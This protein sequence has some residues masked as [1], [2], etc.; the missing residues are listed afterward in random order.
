MHFNHIQMLKRKLYYNFIF[1]LVTFNTIWRRR[2]SLAK[3]KLVQS[4]VSTLSNRTHLNY[5][6]SDLF[7]FSLL[8]LTI[9]RRVCSA[10]Y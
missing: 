6:M 5:C 1:K 7:I 8:C 10:L 4:V 9:V 3:Q 2:F